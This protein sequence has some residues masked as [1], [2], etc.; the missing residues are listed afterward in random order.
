[1]H[2]LAAHPWI[3]FTVLRLL[4]FVVPLV[5]S[6]LLGA[7]LALAAILAAII[8][9]ALSVIFLPRLRTAMANDVA[10]R[11]GK[12]PAPTSDEEA[13]DLATDAPSTTQDVANTNAKPTP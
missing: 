8:A 12:K 10:S 2:R 9:L 6:S 7:D 11:I 1:V 3:V 5:V 13:E 4:L